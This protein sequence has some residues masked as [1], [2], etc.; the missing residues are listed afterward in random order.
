MSYFRNNANYEY[1]LK[2][3]IYIAILHSMVLRFL[4]LNNLLKDFFIINIDINLFLSVYCEGIDNN[5]V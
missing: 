4:N 3:I 2:Y 5:Y 1:S